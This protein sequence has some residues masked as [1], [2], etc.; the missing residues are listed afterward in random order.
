MLGTDVILLHSGIVMKHH[1]G[2]RGRV[3]NGGQEL[4]LCRLSC[5]NAPL[6][7]EGKPMF[8]QL[9]HPQNAYS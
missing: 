4:S 1:A 6:G 2:G 3:R 7:S 8:A 9:D 5:D